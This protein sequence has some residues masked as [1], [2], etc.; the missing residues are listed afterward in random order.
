M[1][2]PCLIYLFLDGI[3]TKDYTGKTLPIKVLPKSTILF[4][5]GRDTGGFRLN[6]GH[7]WV[8]LLYFNYGYFSCKL[9]VDLAEINI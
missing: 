1:E 9:T 3:S 2:Q 8:T 5:I 4:F 7:Q 6:P